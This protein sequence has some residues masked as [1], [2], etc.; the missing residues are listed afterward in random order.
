MNRRQAGHDADAKKPLGSFVPAYAPTSGAFPATDAR[1][2]H[3]RVVAGRHRYVDQLER[4]SMA[5]RLARSEPGCICPRAC[6]R[7][8][9]RNADTDA[10]ERR[11]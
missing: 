6:S 11:S 4:G 5:E 2:M 9:G 1:H 7:I 8:D 10:V 3:I